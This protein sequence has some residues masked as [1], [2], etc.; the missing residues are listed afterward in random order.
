MKKLEL[1]IALGIVP[2]L[3]FIVILP[4]SPRWLISK[5]RIPEAKAILTKALKM[6]NL[7]LSRLEKLDQAK[8]TDSK[9]AKTVFFTDLFKYP[10]TRRNILCMS[11]CWFTISMGYYGLIYNTPTFGWNL[12]ITF[13]MPTFFTL[14]ILAIQP[15]LENRLGR[16]LM[17]TSLLLISGILLLCTLTIPNG[18]FAHN[19]PVMVF[20]WVGQ[21][22]CNIAF[23]VGYVFAK[24]LFPTTHRAL[25][26]SLASACARMGSIASPYVALLEAYDPIYSLTVY[27]GFLLLGAIV[28]AWIWPDTRKTKFPE[29]LEECEKMASTQNNWFSRCK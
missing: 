18:M 27:G 5:G 28:S 25:A 16:K 1:F 14:P 12:Y 2:Y 6:N 23:G 7:P 22:S 11:F 19:W 21:I 29:T 4:E 9:E 26:L 8:L 24:E 20:A 3:F 10:G 17:M 13:A 15:F